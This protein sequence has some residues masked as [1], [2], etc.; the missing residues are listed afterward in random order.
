MVKTDKIVLAAVLALAMGTAHTQE[1]GEWDT[2]AD[3]VLGQNEFVTGARETD[4]FGEWDADDDN[5][6]TENEFYGG[7]YST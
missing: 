5:L 4:A 7:L 3:G 6:V 1:Y 2:D